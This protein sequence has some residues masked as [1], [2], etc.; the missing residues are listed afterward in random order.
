MTRD[1]NGSFEPK[2]VGKHQGRFT[3]LDDKILTVGATGAL[4]VRERDCGDD[5]RVRHGGG[6]VSHAPCSSRCRSQRARLNDL[7]RQRPEA[8]HDGCGKLVADSKFLEGGRQ[9][10]RDHFN[11]DRSFHK[12]RV[13]VCRVSPE[14]GRPGGQSAL[15][16]RDLAPT[17]SHAGG[18]SS[19]G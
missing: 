2:I 16:I 6:A 8:L 13:R 5:A 7:R 17:P 15:A 1:R 18:R 11:Q 19:A 3:G 10:A 9:I 4:S 14:S 12:L